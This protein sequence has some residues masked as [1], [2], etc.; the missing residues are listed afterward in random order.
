[1]TDAAHTSPGICRSCK[2][3]IVW[4]RQPNGK[5]HPCDPPIVS[6]ITAEGV[7][8][9]GRRSHFSTCPDA[10]KWRQQPPAA[11]AAAEPPEQA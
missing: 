7:L 8:V 2:A 4:V 10:S 11:H 1:M 5:N 3:P 6:V 9:R